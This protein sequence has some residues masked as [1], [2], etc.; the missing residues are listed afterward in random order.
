MLTHSAS[1]AA[2]SGQGVYLFN[3]CILS[4]LFYNGVF[5]SAGAYYQNVHLIPSVNGGTGAYR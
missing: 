1:A 5:S 2:V 4:E 3:F